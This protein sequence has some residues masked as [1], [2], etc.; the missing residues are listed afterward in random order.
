[1]AHYILADDFDYDSIIIKGISFTFDAN[2][3]NK[4][5]LVITYNDDETL[6]GETNLTDLLTATQCQRLID[7]S[8]V[9]YP[10]INA[11]NTA[12]NN[13]LA[14]YDKSSVVDS[15]ISTAISNA[16]A[17]YDT[18]VV[19]DTKV[20][21][22]KL[23]SILFTYN[24][25]NN[26]IDATLTFGDASLKYGSVTIPLSTTTSAGLMSASDKTKLDGIET[27]ANRYVS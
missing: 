1:M 8:L 21:N 5:T 12:I 15:K 22:A 3:N 27:G 2:S 6:T 16:L 20:S 24:A 4:L 11:M 23:N 13:A 18:S 17:S 10:T 25:T 14:S 19:V 26:T 7:A 9:S